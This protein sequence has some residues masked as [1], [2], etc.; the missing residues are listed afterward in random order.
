MFNFFKRNHKNDFEVADIIQRMFDRAGITTDRTDNMFHTVID[1]TNTSFNTA[2]LGKKKQLVVYA[3]FHLPVPRW[4]MAGVKLEINRLNSLADKAQIIAREEDGKYELVAIT[5]VT[6]NNAPTI[7]EVQKLMINNIDLIDNHNYRSLVCSI[8]GFASYNE[9]QKQ[10]MTNITKQN[11]KGEVQIEMQDTYREFLDEVLDIHHS[12]FCGCLV[13]LCMTI[14]SREYSEDKASK[15]LDSQVPF[16]ELIQTA[17]NKATNEE[18]DVM[19]KLCV[20]IAWKN[21][22]MDED[23]SED[24][25]GRME[26]AILYAESVYSLLNGS[27]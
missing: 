20:I 10:M 25:R 13:W 11:A 12:R 4:S 19:R 8:M 7:E 6:F 26:A 3:P 23:A 2:L 5:E 18:K 21:T 16:M 15:L 17:Y 24:M 27:H 22:H 1:G 9:F 14:I